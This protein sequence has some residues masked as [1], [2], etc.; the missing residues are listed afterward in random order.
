MVYSVKYGPD[1]WACELLTR[2]GTQVRDHGFNGTQAVR[3]IREAVV[4]GHGIGKSAMTAWLVDW[5]MSTSAA[6]PGIGLK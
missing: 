3:A 2:I 6:S 4:S 5:I 1:A